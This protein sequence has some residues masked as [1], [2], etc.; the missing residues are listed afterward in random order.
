MIL[1]RMGVMASPISASAPPVT[2][3][4]IALSGS[5]QLDPRPN[6]VDL[7]WDSGSGYQ[8]VT[9]LADPPFNKT[10]C[11]GITTLTVASG[12]AIGFIKFVDPAGPS[13]VRYQYVLNNS[14]CASVDSDGCGG[15]DLGTAEGNTTH[16]FVIRMIDTN[17]PFGPNLFDI[18]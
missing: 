4:T 17:P 5:Y 9:T 15:L 11:H 12:S 3:Y 16:A 8:Y 2:Q 18:C 14:S 13:D 10:E 1:T 6:D 7:Y